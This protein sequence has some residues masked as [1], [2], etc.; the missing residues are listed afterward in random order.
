MAVPRPRLVVAHLGGAAN[1]ATAFV[2][3]NLATF[4]RLLPPYYAGNRLGL[5]GSMGDAFAANLVSP[6]RGLLVFSPVVLLAVAGLV[7][8]RRQRS[9]SLLD[10]VAACRVVPHLLA[11]S[12]FR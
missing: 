4:D 11:I 8:A 2:A 10:A 9:F 12:A 7:V 5:P 1:V 3:V 6:N